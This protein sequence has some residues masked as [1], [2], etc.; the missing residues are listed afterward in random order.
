MK[1]DFES[2]G[3]WSKNNYRI[4]IGIGLAFILI[5]F[6]LFVVKQCSDYQDRKD[7]N[8]LGGNV[9]KLGN[10]ANAINANLQ[11]L[12]LQNVNQTILVNQLNQ[13]YN[14]AK[15]DVDNARE[16]TNNALENVNRLNAMNYNNKTLTEAQKARCLAMP[17]RCR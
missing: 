14:S 2:L 11:N 3:V 13:N 15:N 12:N 1:I 9:N 16:I 5:L 4:L 8:G 17:E 10:V 7:I 6:F